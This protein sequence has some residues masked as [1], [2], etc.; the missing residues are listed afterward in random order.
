MKR[1]EDAL[2]KGDL[3]SGA[4]AQAEA[5]AALNQAQ[6]SAEEARR[7]LAD[8]E[9]AARRALE[10]AQRRLAD[11][12]AKAAEEA[13]QLTPASPEGRTQAAEAASALQQAQQAMQQ[14]AQKSSGG[15]SKGASGSQQQAEEALDKAEK[16]LDELSKEGGSSEDSAERL[17]ELKA[18]QDRVREDLK[19]LEE[20]LKEAEAEEAQQNAQQAK[21]SMEE[22]SDQMSQGSAGGAQPKAEEAREYL[23]E[24]KKQLEDEK[25]RYEALQQQEMLF[26]LLK[27]LKKYK[28]QEEAL[29]AAT[30]PL[31]EALERNERLTRPEKQQARRLGDEQVDLATGVEERQKAVAEEGS[32]A[33]A[34]VLE[35]VGLDMRQIAEMLHG[36]DLGP[37]VLGMQDEVIHRLDGLIG[38]F[39]DAIEQKAEEGGGPPPDGQSGKPP[40]VPGIVEIKL[41][42]RLQQDLN[43]KIDSFWKRNPSVQRQEVD[44]LQRRLLERFSHQQARVEKA[45]RELYRQIFPDEGGAGEPGGPDGR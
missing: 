43:V 19:R 31:V 8:K 6:R 21:Q 38:G 37:L 27:D 7:D 10:E 28:E 25:R 40:L 1:A 3:D 39:T 13:R 20:M 18:E 16:A 45:F 26:Q 36:S 29:R 22:S 23:E 14:A 12:T 41:L 42:R 32:I 15:D 17:K 5:L 35:E 11:K 2:S 9:A 33:F 44:D 4:K 24:M 30:A 34:S